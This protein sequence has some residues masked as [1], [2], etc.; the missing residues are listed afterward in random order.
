MRTFNL[1][2]TQTHMAEQSIVSTF[3]HQRDLKGKGSQKTRVCLLEIKQQGSLLD[4]QILSGG[5]AC[6]QGAGM[7]AADVHAPPKNMN[8]GV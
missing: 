5:S 4:T 8:R 2:H 3:N 6:L 7:I 1:T